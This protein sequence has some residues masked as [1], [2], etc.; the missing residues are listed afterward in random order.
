VLLPV[1]IDINGLRDPKFDRD[2]FDYLV[3]PEEIKR[4]LKTLARSNGFKANN[5]HGKSFTADFISGKGEGQVFLLHGKPGVGKTC[6]A[7]MCASS[8]LG[9]WPASRVQVTDFVRSEC[10]A[11]YA[12]RPLLSVTSGDLGTT[13][14]EFDMHLSMFFRLGE[15]WGAIVLID[16]ADIYFEERNKNELERNGLV[17][18]KFILPGVA[19]KLRPSNTLTPAENSAV[20][21]PR[22][23]SWDFVSH[24][25]PCWSH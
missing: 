6:A 13:A 24:H 18:G 12:Q 3:L 8:K 11:E 15:S 5:S 19:L 16:E 14:E 4:T 21:S 23:L 2:L 10:I 7:G 22:I 20:A 17:S 1:V 9:H 25:E